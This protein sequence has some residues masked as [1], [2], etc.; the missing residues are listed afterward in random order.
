MNFL[1]VSFFHRLLV[2]KFLARVD[3]NR[4]PFSR[5]HLSKTAIYRVIN[6]SGKI[7]TDFMEAFI[8]LGNRLF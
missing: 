1:T 8:I 5:L 4:V 3:C 6:V 2:D 7:V